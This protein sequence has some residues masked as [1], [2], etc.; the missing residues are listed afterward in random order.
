MRKRECIWGN[1]RNKQ[2]MKNLCKRKWKHWSILAS[3]RKKPSRIV[4]KITTAVKNETISHQTTVGMCYCGM[5][6]LKWIIEPLSAT[7]MVMRFFLSRQRRRFVDERNCLSD[8]GQS[9]QRNSCGDAAVGAKKMKNGRKF[10]LEV[11]EI[12]H[13][14]LIKIQHHT[15]FY[16]HVFVIAGLLLISLNARQPS[17]N[18]WNF[19]SLLTVNSWGSWLNFY[20]VTT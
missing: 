12:R 17:T 2:T 9:R 20:S 7:K 11:N 19:F 3:Y 16:V 8:D 4:E 13:R 10:R 5:F 18:L 14:H 1:R 6:L 15:R